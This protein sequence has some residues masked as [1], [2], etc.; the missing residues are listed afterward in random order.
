MVYELQWQSINIELSNLLEISTL[1]WK[2][3]CEI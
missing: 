3:K 2:I 1:N